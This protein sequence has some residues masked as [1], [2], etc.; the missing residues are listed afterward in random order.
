MLHDGFGDHV[1]DFY[2]QVIRDKERLISLQAAERGT[3]PNVWDDVLNEARITLWEVLVK[4]PDKPPAYAHRATGMRIVEV[5][6]R[7]V[8]TGMEGHRGRAID[9]IRRTDRDSFDDPDLGLE[10]AA[11]DVLESVQLAYHHGEILQ[12]IAALPA[13]HRQYCYLRFWGGY[14]NVEI[15]AIQ[16]V[17]AGNMARMWT[18]SIAPKLAD[19]L[20]HLATV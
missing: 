12:A 3:D 13:N 19:S 7:G 18:E 11:A 4:H 9:P 8:W 1:E 14:T 16:G 20:A 10:V 15:A 2:E 6:T 5:L 17:K